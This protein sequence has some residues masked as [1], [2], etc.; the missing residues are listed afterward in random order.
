MQITGNV[1]SV[2]AAGR[3]SVII[4]EN[5]HGLNEFRFL[6]E[7]SE[8]MTDEKPEKPE[9]IEKSGTI[10]GSRF[11]AKRSGRGGGGRLPVHQ[12]QGKKHQ[13]HAGHMNDTD[14][15]LQQQDA[16]KHGSDGFQ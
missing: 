15:L 1:F 7:K 6:M 11:A 3:H 16:D 5:R 12:R 14:L 2:P 10:D 4:T 13:H 8:K 9:K